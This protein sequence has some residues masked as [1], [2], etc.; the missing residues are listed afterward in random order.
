MDDS[1]L[2]M[3][4]TSSQFSSRGTAGERGFGIGLIL[5]AE[6]T[7]LNGGSISVESRPNKGSTFTVSLPKGEI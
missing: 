2:N 3:L 5:C 1:R 4:F 7:R 6:F